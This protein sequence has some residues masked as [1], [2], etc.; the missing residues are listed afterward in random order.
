MSGVSN[1]E[2][3]VCQSRDMYVNKGFL[4]TD[5]SLVREKVRSLIFRS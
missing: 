4:E 5:T 2:S 3:G 1:E